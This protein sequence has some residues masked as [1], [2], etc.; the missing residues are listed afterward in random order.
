[1]VGL[2][3]FARRRQDFGCAGLDPERDEDRNIDGAEATAD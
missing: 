2:A 3:T 1:L